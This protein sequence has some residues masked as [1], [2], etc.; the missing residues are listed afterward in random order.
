MTTSTHPSSPASDE[1]SSA[2]R[3]AVPNPELLLHHE[4]DGIQ[5]YDNPLPR[6]WVLIFWG[7]FWFAVAYFLAYHVFDRGQSVKAAYEEEVAVVAAERA[8]AALKEKVSEESLAALAANPSVVPA[9]KEVFALRCT[10]CHGAE[11]Q[12]VIGP[13]LT[14]NSWIHGKGK[15]MDIY[16]VV[17]EGVAAKGMPAWGQ[18]LKPEDVRKVVA[19]VASL[20]G[21]NLPGKA[22]EGTPAE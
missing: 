21:K 17:N 14:D 8:R 5:E 11:G 12:G 6:W 20:R 22:P 19:F 18:Q 9:G 16:A 10:P 15:L 2:P 7:S 3:E 4:Y 13:N 1:S